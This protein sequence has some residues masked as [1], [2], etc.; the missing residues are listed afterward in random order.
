MSIDQEQLKE[1]VDKCDVC[2]VPI[3]DVTRAITKESADGLL[4]F[5]TSKCYE[6][7]MADPLMYADYEEDDS[8]E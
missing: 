3:K 6:N 1:S 7:Y 5:C 2:R 8:L 4:N